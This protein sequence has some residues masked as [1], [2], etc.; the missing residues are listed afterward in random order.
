MRGI[1]RQAE[2]DDLYEALSVVTSMSF[3][4]RSMRPI[5]PRFVHLLLIWVFVFRFPQILR[6]WCHWMFGMKL[7]GLNLNVSVA[8]G[9]SI[10]WDPYLYESA[11]HLRFD[12]LLHWNFLIPN[13]FTKAQQDGFTLPRRY[14]SFDGIPIDVAV[15][16]PRQLPWKVSAGSKPRAPRD[17]ATQS[18][19][20]HNSASPASADRSGSRPPKPKSGAS[21]PIAGKSRMSLAAQNGEFKAEF[22]SQ[23]GCIWAN[24]Q[25]R[26][27]STSPAPEPISEEWVAT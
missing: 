26:S 14:R 18:P 10:D 7:T 22:E 21:T 1:S 17:R 23:L 15:E 5:R 12:A 8:C 24:D 9:S 6:N 3:P 13:S 11:D 25:G 16:M 4:K 2:D 27:P 19:A 20:L